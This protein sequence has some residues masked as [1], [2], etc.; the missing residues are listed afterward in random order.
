MEC[1]SYI[2]LAA[3]RGSVYDGGSAYAGGR[4]PGARKWE[5]RK[6]PRRPGDQ[7]ARTAERRMPPPLLVVRRVVWKKARESCD[8]PEAR[9]GEAGGG[10]D[11]GGRLGCGGEA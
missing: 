9:E 4:K 6:A 11:H 8:A 3:L 7:A 5:D 2:C 10:T 1:I